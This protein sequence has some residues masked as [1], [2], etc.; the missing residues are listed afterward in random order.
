M[1]NHYWVDSHRVA[2]CRASRGRARTCRSADKC[3]HGGSDRM[4][5]EPALPIL[6]PSLVALTG[7]PL[8]SVP[9]YLT[10]TTRAVS[11]T[12]EARP[13]STTSAPSQRIARE[14]RPRA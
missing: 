9:R 2:P 1:E 10:T 14:T 3:A 5:A 8:R 13:P 4:T 12:G 11:F 7:G 6:R